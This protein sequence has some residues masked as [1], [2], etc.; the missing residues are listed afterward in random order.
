M[1]DDSL[2]V[3]SC[4]ECAVYMYLESTVNVSIRRQ[5][6]KQYGAVTANRT[7]YTSRFAHERTCTFRLTSENASNTCGSSTG[8]CGSCP[9]VGSVCT[10]DAHCAIGPVRKEAGHH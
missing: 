3:T 2:G 9:E 10:A 6:S 8:V 5:N 7:L 1:P 4:A